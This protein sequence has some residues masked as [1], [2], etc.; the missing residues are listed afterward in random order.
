LKDSRVHTPRAPESFSAL[1]AALL[2]RRN[3][4]DNPH[5]STF[6]YKINVWELGVPIIS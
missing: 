5:F 4:S 6:K 1:K 3:D 2:R